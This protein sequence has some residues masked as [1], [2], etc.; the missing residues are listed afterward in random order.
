MYVIVWDVSGSMSAEIGG[1]GLKVLTGNIDRSTLSKATNT[2]DYVVI[3]HGN[4]L[5]ALDL[6]EGVQADTEE[7]WLQQAELIKPS[8]P[9]K[10]AGIGVFRGVSYA[11][12]HN[13]RAT[14]EKIRKITGGRIHVVSYA[15]EDQIT[16]RSAF[17]ARLMRFK[18]RIE[19][20]SS[21]LADDLPWHLLEPSPWPENLV[22]VYL[23]LVAKDKSGPDVRNE[24]GDSVWDGATDE[25]AEQAQRY[26]LNASD[27]QS[28]IKS[29][30]SG[31][32]KKGLTAIGKLFQK[33]AAEQVK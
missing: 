2:D 25:F 28:E 16:D 32:H 11:G 27:G 3:V 12:T 19:T 20:N 21:P 6:Y 4:V 17:G 7:L 8:L 23:A 1:L 31:D 15:V 9:P 26:G 30:R 22:S 14:A 13:G 24:I 33:I 10:C 5:D 18:E 29:A